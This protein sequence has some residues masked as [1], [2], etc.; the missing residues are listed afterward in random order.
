MKDAR[1]QKE[2]EELEKKQQ[3]KDKK[4]AEAAKRVEENI[5]AKGKSQPKLD[6]L[7]EAAD[8]LEDATD[9]LK[10]LDVDQ[11]FEV[12]EKTS[13]DKTTLKMDLFASEVARF[14]ISDRAAAALWNGAIR[15]LEDNDFLE[16][17]GDGPLPKT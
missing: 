17:K 7:E 1:A 3:L 14:G 6:S 16:K 13:T 8:E 9:N 12:H 5:R 15:A 2:K 4:K 10:S 11:D